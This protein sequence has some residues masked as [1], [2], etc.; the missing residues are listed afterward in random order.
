MRKDQHKTNADNQK[1]KEFEERNGKCRK[2]AFDTDQ[3]KSI[4]Q[5]KLKQWAAMQNENGIFFT[6]MS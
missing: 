5:M 2:T 3:H 6:R 4:L 1:K